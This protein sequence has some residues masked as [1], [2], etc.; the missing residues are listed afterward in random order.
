MPAEHCLIQMLN[1]NFANEA[2]SVLQ[3]LQVL[4]V[5]QYVTTWEGQRAAEAPKNCCP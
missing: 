5:Y 1:E 4:T 3:S 2:T